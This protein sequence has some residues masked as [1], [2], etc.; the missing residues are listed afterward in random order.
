MRKINY[1]LARTRKIDGRAFALTL[2]V[3]LLALVAFNAVTLFNLGRLQRQ[4]RAEKKDTRFIVQK[5][6]SMKQKTL[7]RQNQIAAWKKTWARRLDF[8]NALIGRKRFSFIARL[9]FLEKACGPGTLVRQLG[10]VNEP[11]GRVQMTVSA[12]AQNQL[13][14]LYKKLLPYELAIASENQSAESYLA[15]LSFRISDE[16]K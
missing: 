5:M 10:I 11:A 8:A 15:R 3:L 9:D 4:H 13:L 16:K 12:L 2:G 14:Q 1:N 7:A 6:A